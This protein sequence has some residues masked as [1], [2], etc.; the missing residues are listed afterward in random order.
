MSEVSGEND[1]D[2][3][4]ERWLLVAQAETDRDGRVVNLLEKSTV[5]G[6]G[7]YRLNFATN[8]YFDRLNAKSFYPFVDVVF[9]I[10]SPGGEHHHVPLLLSPFGY[11]TY[12]GS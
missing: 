7:I 11:S 12:K 1:N 4:N 2:G 10:H 6:I 5:L 8:V 3:T 9:N